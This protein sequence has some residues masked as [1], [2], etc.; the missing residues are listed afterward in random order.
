MSVATMEGEMRVDRIIKGQAGQVLHFRFLIPE[1]GLGYHGV[2][3]K[4]YRVLFLKRAGQV[5]E[6]ASPYY[7]VSSSIIKHNSKPNSLRCGCRGAR[8]CIA[9]HC[10]FRER[11]EGSDLGVACCENERSNHALQIA[12]SAHAVFR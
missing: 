4:S 1:F 12:A 7:I 5:L 2:S 11:Q 3:P 6:F 9:I 10:N 8:D